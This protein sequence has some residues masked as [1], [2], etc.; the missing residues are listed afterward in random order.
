MASDFLNADH[1]VE[2]IKR[3]VNKGKFNKDMARNMPEFFN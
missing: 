3:L 2:N 1:E